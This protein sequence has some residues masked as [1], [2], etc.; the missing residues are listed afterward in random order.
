MAKYNKNSYNYY[1]DQLIKSLVAQREKQL[2]EIEK[3]VRE[4]L[5]KHKFYELD[6]ED[7]KEFI[8]EDIGIRLIEGMAKE[9]LSF[10]QIA[11]AF[12]ISQKQFHEIRKENDL[13]YDAIDSGR[14]E[15]LNIVEKSLFESATDRFVE[16]TKT[17]K[18]LS[19]RNQDRE[20]VS[21]ETYKKFIPGN[22]RAQ[23]YI[24]SRQKAMEYRS[25]L[26]EEL[27]SRGKLVSFVI[28]LPGVEL[29]DDGDE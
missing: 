12:E 27:D 1:Q 22:Y 14:N 26:E 10:V 9:G 17:Y 2:I 21:T 20:V 11:R 18:K 7:K 4:F 6:F 19:G 8:G 28:A 25:K 3:K 13:V 16:E 29:D 15:K 23:E 5:D 24:L